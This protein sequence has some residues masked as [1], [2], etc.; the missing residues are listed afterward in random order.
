MSQG[1][2]EKLSEDIHGNIKKA[3]ENGS[4]MNTGN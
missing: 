2:L 4:K 3:D 1:A